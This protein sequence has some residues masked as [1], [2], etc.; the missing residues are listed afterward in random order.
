[1]KCI[2]IAS[3]FLIG[4]QQAAVGSVKSENSGQK[5]ARNA[6]GFVME[7]GITGNS[8]VFH[9]GLTP[10]AAKRTG[11]GDFPLFTGDQVELVVTTKSNAEADLLR[12]LRSKQ[13]RI[14]LMDLTGQDT[15]SIEQPLCYGWI[16]PDDEAPIF[17]P[18]K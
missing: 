2:F 14:C 13:K 8:F 15:G 7:D 4:F 17:L 10:P 3:V 16:A 5:E 1:M 12:E 9:V 6:C 11:P 18:S